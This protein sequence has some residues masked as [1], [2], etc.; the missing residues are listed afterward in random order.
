MFSGDFIARVAVASGSVFIEIYIS[1]ISL[2]GRVA[3]C[4]LPRRFDIIGRKRVS[5]AYKTGIPHRSGTIRHY[6]EPPVTTEETKQNS[7]P[8]QTIPGTIVSIVAL[9]QQRVKPNPGANVNVF[10]YLRHGNTSEIAAD[11]HPSYQHRLCAASLGVC[12][13]CSI[14][15]AEENFLVDENPTCSV[16]ALLCCVGLWPDDYGH[17]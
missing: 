13:G 15:L 16:P 4:S 6:I 3:P 7:P 12:G 8:S 2:Y 14:L 5:I 1:N 17:S 9:C 10:L 11:A